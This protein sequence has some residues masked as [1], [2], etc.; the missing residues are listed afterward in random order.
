MAKV[1]QGK[2]SSAIIHLVPNLVSF[3]LCYST[4]HL[5]WQQPASLPSLSLWDSISLY[6]GHHQI[7]FST[8]TWFL[9]RLSKARSLIMNNALFPSF[10]FYTNLLSFHNIAL[11]EFVCVFVFYFVKA[12]QH[13]QLTFPGSSCE[14]RLSCRTLTGK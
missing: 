10:L 2:P 4:A 8:H 3:P 7:D 5:A 14:D 9:P 6:R 11:L 1:T 13:C 12:S